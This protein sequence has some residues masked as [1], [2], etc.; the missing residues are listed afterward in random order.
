MYRNSTSSPTNFV[1]D[2][3]TSSN[4]SP[5][6]S[7]RRTNSRGFD[8]MT[9]LAPGYAPSADDVMVGRGKRCLA[10]SGNLRFKQIVATKLSS[11]LAAECR[12]DKTAILMEVIATVRANSP[13]G[14]FIKQNPKTG[15]FFEVGD[16][17]AKEKTAQAFRDALHEYYSSSNPSKKKR[18]IQ[19]TVSSEKKASSSNNNNTQEESGDGLSSS[20]HHSKQS[21]VKAMHSQY[22]RKA[23]SAPSS[24]SRD[25]DDLEPI[26][27]VARSATPPPSFARLV[28]VETPKDTSN[29]DHPGADYSNGTTPPDSQQSKR[30]N[31]AVILGDTLAML[32]S[33]LMD[34]HF[35]SDHES[36][37]E[38]P[39]EPIPLAMYGQEDD[40]EPEPL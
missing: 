21:L 4:R 18:R 11:Y 36:E 22:T 7:M 16:F 10:H 25:C 19:S 6:G 15:Q 27:L 26:A 31:S 17:L 35:A 13:N 39:F 34:T 3:S 32:S 30:K 20:S 14:G 23:K 40:F 9:P 29:E 5:S 38:D 33:A 24:P 28:T 12:V 1:N 2:S 8:Q 37:S